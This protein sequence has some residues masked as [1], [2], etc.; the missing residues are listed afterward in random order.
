MKTQTM[1]SPTLRKQGRPHSPAC[2]S[3]LS[4]LLA[5]WLWVPG[6]PAAE[7]PKAADLPALL[8]KGLFEE[9]VNRNF[10]AA[11][12]EYRA[13]A[14]QF[15]R[16][17]NY[18]ATAIFRLA[19]CQRKLGRTNEAQI[20]YRRIT[21]EFPD[22][23]NLVQISQTQ[24]NMTA[25]TTGGTAPVATVTDG[26]FDPETLEIRR[27][28]SMIKNSPDLINVRTGGLTPLHQAATKGQLAVA[29]YLLGSGADIE[30]TTAFVAPKGNNAPLPGSTSLM[31]A[32]RV[33]HRSMVGLLLN[34]GAKVNTTITSSGETALH[35]AA[36]NGFK[37]VVQTLLDN[38]A[39]VNAPDKSKGTPLLAATAY[40]HLAV[41]E[42]LLSRG[43]AVDAANADGSTPL[44]VALMNGHRAL[45]ERLLAAKADLRKP[46]RKG[47]TPFYL[48]VINNQFPLARRLNEAGV[49]VDEP[50]GVGCA[51]LLAAMQYY[52]SRSARHP[53]GTVTRPEGSSE[54]IGFLLDLKANPNVR[55][56]TRMEFR[57]FFIQKGTALMAAA[58]GDMGEV[59]EMLARHGA[60]V[61]ARDDNGLTALNTAVFL[62]HTN[63]AVLLLRHQADPNLGTTSF[64]APLSLAAE[65]G[66]LDLARSMLENK[67]DTNIRNENGQTPLHVAV[68]KRHRELA[69]LLL[70]RGADPSLT[71]NDKNTP[72]DLLN[73]SLTGWPGLMPAPFG[74]STA[75]RGTQED[76]S[77]LLRQ[78]GASILTP[79]P[80]LITIVRAGKNQKLMVM[81]E[82][83]NGWNRFA[84]LEIVAASFDRPP[85]PV[86]PDWTTI[87]ILRRA[88]EGK[89]REI[90][91]DLEELFKAGGKD[92]PLEWG[93]V[94]DI[95]EKDHLAN[96][97]WNDLSQADKGR[98]NQRLEGKITVE[99]KGMTNQFRWVPFPGFDPK[100]PTDGTYRLKGF[101][102]AWLAEF[103]ARQPALYLATSDLSRV[104]VVRTDPATG[105]RREFLEDGRNNNLASRLWLRDGDVLRI[106]EKN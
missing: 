86:F 47:E 70:E 53:D 32:A 102:S 80:G 72:L 16:Q 23:T 31:L 93:D 22:L 90:P 67:A 76:L 85:M 7:A 19:E 104:T 17:R 11:A 42:L 95:P 4:A 92:V 64:G 2:L 71:D 89:A 34:H 43:A 25:P 5:V 97:R 78:H 36:E 37:A 26:A 83:T 59:A 99:V 48:A 21:R 69:A 101:A 41:V 40:G 51:P 65:R 24:L 106:P 12:A 61:N 60:E 63:L 91:V 84:L 14:S 77:A 35:Q 96:D 39:D 38:Q 8:Q 105:T 1:P 68:G 87:R 82:N 18:G 28:E 56:P 88:A 57:G 100:D 54:A 98:F 103:L 94:V 45:A 58:L 33:G 55:H 52:V 3:H 13:A 66:N 27:I 30:S 62:N 50:D 75:G 79:R 9:E 10:E 73:S 15:D 44:H 49:S 46:N 6:L 20:L 81:Q 74:M 29:T